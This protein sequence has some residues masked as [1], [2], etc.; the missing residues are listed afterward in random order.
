MKKNL[1]LFLMTVLLLS[2]CSSHE[3]DMEK[4]THADTTAET[5]ALAEGTNAETD[6]TTQAPSTE[7]FDDNTIYVSYATEKMAS[8]N[9]NTAGQ[10]FELRSYQTFHDLTQ[11]EHT[12]QKGKTD[13]VLTVG[14]EEKKFVY[15]QTTLVTLEGEIVSERSCDRYRLKSGSGS[16]R[17]NYDGTL[18]YFELYDLKE[19]NGTVK[20]TN[21]K[22]KEIVREFSKEWLPE[23]NF[24]G[25]S[26]HI[27][28]GKDYGSSVAYIRYLHGY[29]CADSCYFYINTDGQ[30]YEFGN[31]D[32][33]SFDAFD[34]ITQ[35]QLDATKQRLLRSVSA[36]VRRPDE[37][38]ILLTIGDDGNLYMQ[39]IA[40]G[41]AFGEDG[42]W[43]EN[44]EMVAETYYARV[45]P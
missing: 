8:I 17:V 32:L 6:V 39:V 13:I 9:L 14:G 45:N 5:Q 37:D 4:Q 30:V 11:V 20:M 18:E 3:N 19:G 33:G 27:K 35:E 16:L 12:T 25:Y 29:R 42:M 1:C 21:E 34:Y 7:I 36:L 38:S 26:P 28:V 10:A 40:S 43:T 2:S 41:M 22:A 23:N 15:E 31:D 24:D 44:M